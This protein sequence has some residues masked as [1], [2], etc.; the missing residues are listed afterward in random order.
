MHI[1]VLDEMPDIPTPVFRLQNTLHLSPSAA[2][3]P[4]KDGQRDDGDATDA[5]HDTT[6][7][8]TDNGRRVGTSSKTYLVAL[9]TVWVPNLEGSK[10]DP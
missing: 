2:T 7:D 9:G 8:R 6:D 1:F 4:E 10:D 3:D 5:S